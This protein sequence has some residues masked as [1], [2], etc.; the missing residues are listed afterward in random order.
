M[1]KSKYQ[2]LFQMCTKKN[3]SI[4]S[5]MVKHEEKLKHTQMISEDA[6]HSLKDD[7]E[8]LNRNGT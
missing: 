8:H 2:K 1:K 4:I 5:K 6:K 7:I 3:V